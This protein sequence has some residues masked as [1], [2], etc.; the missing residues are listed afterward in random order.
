GISYLKWDANRD[1]TEPGS[2][3]LAPDRQSHLPI[4]R[5]HATSEVMAEVARRPADVELMLCASGGGRSDLAT[6]THFHELWTSDNTDPVDRLSIQW[7]ASHLLPAKVLGAHVTHWG[8]KPV[9][10]G[11]AVA[12]S[13]RF[14]FDLDLTGLSQEDL[15]ACEQAAERYFRIRE[16]VQ[17][18]DLHR[19][20]SPHGTDRCALAYR[21]P[22]GE[23]GV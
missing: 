5:I 19:L 14:G 22:E 21:D 8:M 17:H 10:F 3:A 4:D 23:A 15:E 2:A 7:G 16:L 12:M 1:I 11:C 20:V 13:A 6:L 18:G 9:P